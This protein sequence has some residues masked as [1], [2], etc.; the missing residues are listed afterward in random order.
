MPSHD[1]YEIVIVG[2]GPLGLATAY[3][4]AQRRPGRSVLVVDALA[5]PGEGSMGA[6]NSM[7]R[8]VFS[9]PDNRALAGASIRFYEHVME[10]EAGW[11]EPVPLLDRYGYLWL[12]S[13]AQ[14]VEFARLLREVA[15]SFD[16]ELVPLEQLAD[17]PGLDRS[18]ARWFEG[19][20]GA[21]PPEIVAAFFGRH[22]GAVAPDLLARFYRGEAERLGVEFAFSTCAQRLSFEGREEILLHDD[23]RPLAF[24]EHVPDRLRI[25]RVHFGS[26]RS[27]RVERVVVAAGAWSANLLSPLGFATAC[28]PRP[29]GS[30]SVAGPGV[31]ALLDWAPHLDP[32]DRDRG[33][34]RLPFLILPSGATL[35]PLY[36]QQRIWLGCLDTTSR[37]IG[38]LEDPVREGRLDFDMGRLASRES[39][40]T[41]ILP[42]VA[43]YLPAFES[44]EVRL[45][46][47][48]GGY[49]NFSPDGLP[50]LATEPYGVAFV[51][52]DSG[53][54]IMKADALGRLAAAWCDGESHARLFTGEEYPVERLSLTNRAVRPERLIL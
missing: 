23:G 44:P 43:P 10:S 48:W 39:Y 50:I 7:V 12:L 9:S 53:S 11:R 35:K 49:Y 27:V 51:G 22:C 4:L 34:P 38:T 30:Y 18:P 3:H 33:R 14:R 28:S 47:C 1:R 40:P 15:G 41:D 17:L 16:G 36:R 13:E 45:D 6:S 26:G 25:A 8:D 54:G 31:D 21:P 52:G 46:R 32:I 24:Q 29:Q 37:P 42:A 2:A 20:A 19:D 5:G